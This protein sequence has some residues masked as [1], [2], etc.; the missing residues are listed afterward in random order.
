MSHFM[1]VCHEVGIDPKGFIPGT[2][3]YR[4]GNPMGHKYFNGDL[5]LLNAR[6]LDLPE[7]FKKSYLVARR[8]RKKEA[9]VPHQIP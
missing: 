9:I 7:T 5:L 6:Q 1:H 8:I 2:L 4:K 3:L